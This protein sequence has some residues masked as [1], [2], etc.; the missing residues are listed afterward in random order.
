MGMDMP[1][2]D[3]DQI[4]TLKSYDG[5]NAQRP[6]EQLIEYLNA[7]FNPDETI[8]YS[9]QTE[10]VEDT[11][12]N[13]N[14]ITKYKPYGQS[15]YH[16]RRL[17]DQLKKHKD[18][19]AVLGDTTPEAGGWICINPM[20]GRGRSRDNVTD[21]RYALIES[22]TMSCDDQ[23]ATY[24]RLNLPIAAMVSSGGKSVHAIVKVNASDHD[25]YRKRVE[26]LFNYAASNGIDVDGQNKN[27]TRLSRMPGISRNGNMQSL[28]ATNIGARDWDEWLSSIRVSKYPKL[29]KYFPPT[30]HDRPRDIVSGLI[31][32][33][34]VCL[35]IGASKAGK[36]QRLQELT[37]AVCEGGKWLGH[38]VEQGDVLYLNMEMDDYWLNDRFNLIWKTTYGKSPEDGMIDHYT[39]INGR[40]DKV[41]D[42][43]EAVEMLEYYAT[44]KR[45]SLI[46]IDPIYLLF[47]GSENDA[48][49]AKA[50][51]K[52]C[53]HLATVTNAAVILAHH[54]SKG[55]QSE[56]NSMDRGSGSG[57]F[58]RAC[59]AMI[60][61]IELYLEDDVKEK[62]FN[63]YGLDSPIGF[64]VSYTMR[65]VKS[66][67]P[68]RMIA[69]FPLLYE[70]PCGLLEGCLFADSQ[71]A[72]S[73]ARQTSK[74]RQVDIDAA[75]IA[76]IFVEDGVEYEYRGYRFNGVQSKVLTEL[77][78]EEDARQAACKQAGIVYKN[79]SKIGHIYVT[80]VDADEITK[81]SR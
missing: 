66:P 57:V 67:S 60:D 18:I 26:Y 46:I 80:K 52:P 78:P 79:L 69:Q 48:E 63:S 54:H 62:I 42:I 71:E 61:M 12:T 77:F 7:L 45:Y 2:Y 19:H 56:K 51:L 25:E 9:F 10:Q 17:I 39:S 14:P 65:N 28:L 16:V 24:R 1:G 33:R 74:T 64:E 58:A 70:D 31:H 81:R 36:T 23:I 47:N 20:D 50:F 21:F 59:D 40:M 29:R 76:D 4:V 37:A 15:S 6:H 5:S 75:T 53:Q 13:G 41:G 49:A 34:E 27:P 44:Q 32:A 11:D 73:K 30:Q 38:Q 68:E 8:S 22:D 72:K 3:Y 55:G 35:L 43:T